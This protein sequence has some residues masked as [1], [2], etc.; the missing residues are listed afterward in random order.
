MI[1][2]WNSN[3]V[4][5][6]ILEKNTLEIKTLCCL[7]SKFWGFEFDLRPSK[8][9]SGQN[10]VAVWKPILK[11]PIQ[12]LLTLST[13]KYFSEV[14]HQSLLLTLSLYIVPISRYLT[15]KLLG[16]DL[17]LRPLEVTWGQNLYHHS[18]AQ[19]WFPIKLLLT[20]PISNRFW[21]IWLQS[22]QGSTLTSDL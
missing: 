7:T 6:F 16:F 10:I 11:F 20:I 2:I 19:T 13:S 21:D 17:D 22:V 18:K 15:S 9:N 1:C 8:V 14:R 5:Y 3:Q 12:H 4:N